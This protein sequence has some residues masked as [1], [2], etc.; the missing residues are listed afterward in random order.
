MSSVSPERCDMTEVYP[1]LCAISTAAIVSVR[2]PIWLTLISIEF[3]IFLSIPLAS[4]FT[5]V[6]N[7]SSPT[8]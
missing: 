6:T 3:A 8:N 1:D 4:R 5:L 2:V 7:K